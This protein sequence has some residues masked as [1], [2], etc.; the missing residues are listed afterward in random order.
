MVE[1]GEYFFTMHG[2]KYSLLIKKKGFSEIAENIELG[3]SEK[4]IVVLEKGYLLKKL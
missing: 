3:V 2:G 1:N 4:E